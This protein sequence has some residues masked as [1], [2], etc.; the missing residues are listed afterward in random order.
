VVDD[1]GHNPAK[2]A[3]SLQAAHLRLGEGGRVLAVFQPHGF[4]PLRFLRTDFVAAFVEELA[5]KDRLWFLDVFYAGGTAARDISSGDVI[6][7]LVAREVR[8]EHAPS[9]EWLV[10]RLVSE[11]RSGDLILVMGARDPSL[12]DLARAILRSLSEGE[13]EDELQSPTL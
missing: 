10:R 8:A 7:D 13:L 6:A 9:R 11:A 5:P 4:G 2:V 3:A 12:T 1:F